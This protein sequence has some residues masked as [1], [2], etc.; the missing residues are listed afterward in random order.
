M[1]EGSLD[2]P[3]KE[4]AAKIAEDKNQFRHLLQLLNDAIIKATK[5]APNDKCSSSLK[6]KIVT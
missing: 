2:I 3:Y 1:P 4:K 5:T 6:R